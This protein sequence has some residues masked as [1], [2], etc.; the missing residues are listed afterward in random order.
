MDIRSEDEFKRVTNFSLELGNFYQDESWF[1]GCG[2]SHSSIYGYYAYI[3]T[4]LPVSITIPEEF[5]KT[6]IPIFIVYRK[7]INEQKE[8]D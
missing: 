6:G 8:E 2:I 4:K 7:E 5:I 3:R 1:N